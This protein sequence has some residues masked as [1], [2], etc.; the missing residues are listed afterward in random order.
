MAEEL[1]D[2]S[3]DSAGIISVVGW[4]DPSKV[5]PDET[6]SQPIH[7]DLAPAGATA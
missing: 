2:F 4:G 6:T 5:H 7:G 3:A 1:P